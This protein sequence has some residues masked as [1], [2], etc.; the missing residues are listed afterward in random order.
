[1]TDKTHNHAHIQNAGNSRVR[2]NVDSGVRAD[3]EQDVEVDSDARTRQNYSNSDSLNSQLLSSLIP[4][5]N[6]LVRNNRD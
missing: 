3:Q 5:L 2:L 4:L 6:R 1:M